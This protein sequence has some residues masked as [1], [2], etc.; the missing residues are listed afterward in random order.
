M[1]SEYIIPLC[2]SGIHLLAPCVEYT[3]EV[4]TIYQTVLKRFRKVRQICMVSELIVISLHTFTKDTYIYMF[5]KTSYLSSEPNRNSLKLLCM[6]GKY[7]LYGTVRC[8]IFI[9]TETDVLNQQGGVGR[10]L[11]KKI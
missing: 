1:I 8:I 11:K 7:I 2:I 3:V 9:F 6:R 10:V 4:S 5:V